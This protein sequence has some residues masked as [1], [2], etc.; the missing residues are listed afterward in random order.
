MYKLRSITDNVYFQ[1][2]LS[3][4]FF[5]L[6]VLYFS[7]YAY[8]LDLIYLFIYFN[9][10]GL[11]TRSTYT[12]KRCWRKDSGDQHLELCGQRQEGVYTWSPIRPTLFAGYEDFG[13]T[14]SRLEFLF[15]SC[16][17]GLDHVVSCH[18][19][20]AK[21]CGSHCECDESFVWIPQCFLMGRFCWYQ[22]LLLAGPALFLISTMELT[23]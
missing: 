22:W 3:I 17:P 4:S 7:A 8:E 20:H 14:W 15:S 16:T 21:T 9:K 18:L 12:S 13:G 2:Y 11:I 23:Q 10:Y 6:H 19:V 5:K 1:Q